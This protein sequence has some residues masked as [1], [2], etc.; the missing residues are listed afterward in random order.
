M[1]TLTP[2]IKISRYL[3][4]FYEI[5]ILSLSR[6]CKTNKNIKVLT[7]ILT[8]NIHVPKYPKGMKIT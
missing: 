1:R 4:T 8:W 3:T 6:G 5:F 7:N 2:L